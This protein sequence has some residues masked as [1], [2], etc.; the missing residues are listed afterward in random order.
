VLVA[1]SLFYV[2]NCSLDAVKTQRD[3]GVVLGAAWRVG[4]SHHF[5]T[6]IYVR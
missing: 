4:A 5:H 2:A 1:A 3:L 6:T